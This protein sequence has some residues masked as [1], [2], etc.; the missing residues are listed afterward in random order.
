MLSLDWL[1]PKLKIIEN[2]KV[3]TSSLLPMGLQVVGGFRVINKFKS[4]ISMEKCTAPGTLEIPPFIRVYVAI[5]AYY[6]L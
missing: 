1:R 5:N 4:R 2:L 3:K 6:V